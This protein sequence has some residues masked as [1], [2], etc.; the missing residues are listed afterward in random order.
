MERSEQYG[1]QGQG[2]ARAASQPLFDLMRHGGIAM[3]ALLT[4]GAATAAVPPPPIAFASEIQT[5]PVIDGKLDDPAWR[6]APVYRDF[7]LFKIRNS[8]L[9]EF[10]LLFD[11]THLYVGIRCHAGDPERFHKR[12]GEM[13]K[14]L[15]PGFARLVGKSAFE[16]SW[17]IEL[18]LDP[19]A[20]GIN[21]Y[22]I[23]YNLAGQYAGHY[24]FVDFSPFRAPLQ[25][26][27]VFRD[28][29]WEAEFVFPVDAFGLREYTAGSQWGFNMVVNEDQ[30]EGI[31]VDVGGIFNEPRRFGR[32]FFG[33]Y[34]LWT[35]Q[36]VDEGMLRGFARIKADKALR[37]DA[38]VAPQIKGLETRI[39]EIGRLREEA[40]SPCDYASWLKLW[41]SYRKA[42][43][44]W[45]RLKH[46]A[47]ILKSE[48]SLP[49]D[50]SHL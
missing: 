35:E 18:F 5:A 24:D 25:S 37:S 44:D 15:A 34:Q 10:R 33:N 7:H 47:D 46:L 22:Q 21:Y 41:S 8:P 26:G 32:L 13:K 27:V 1:R 12:S 45:A 38:S 6:E 4:A 14:M 11:R 31:W 3:A 30:A 23:L 43:A 48:Q 40:G 17:G 19:G 2:R 39:G 9:A 49:P 50:Q 42:E 29:G 20:S 28:D 16:N 36:I